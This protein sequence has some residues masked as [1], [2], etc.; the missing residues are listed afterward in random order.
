MIL[1]SS[2]INDLSTTFWFLL[3]VGAL[4]IAQLYKHHAIKKT[5]ITLYI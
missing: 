5:D 2:E 3:I 1:D 4:V